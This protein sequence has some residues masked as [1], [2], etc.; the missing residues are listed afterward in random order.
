MQNLLLVT[1]GQSNA[2]RY[3]LSYWDIKK[4]IVVG[5][6]QKIK[7]AALH[8]SADDRRQKRQ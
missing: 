7:T 4:L 6:L 1:L 2:P 3:S 5:L 8:D